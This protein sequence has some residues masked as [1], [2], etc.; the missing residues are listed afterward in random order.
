VSLKITVIIFQPDLHGIS[1]AFPSYFPCIS[2]AF[3]SHFRRILLR[4]GVWISN[5]GGAERFFQF[6]VNGTLFSS[7]LSVKS[8][9]T[10]FF[11]WFSTTPEFV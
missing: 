9:G 10:L 6:I 7:P 5:P 1:A 11:S 4:C 2:A 3:P 8:G